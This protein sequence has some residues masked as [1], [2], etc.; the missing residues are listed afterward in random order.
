MPLCFLLHFSQ[1]EFGN[2]LKTEISYKCWYYTVVIL[3]FLMSDCGLVCFELEGQVQG[4]IC[5]FLNMFVSSSMHISG[6][7]LHI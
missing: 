3:P 4:S 5:G 6:W 1:P 2:A 7:D